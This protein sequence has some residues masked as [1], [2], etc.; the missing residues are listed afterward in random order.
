MCTSHPGPSVYEFVELM[1]VISPVAVVLFPCAA[2]IVLVSCTY[3]MYI[4]V[5]QFSISPSR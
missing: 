1:K 5:G 4:S 3:Y 2:D